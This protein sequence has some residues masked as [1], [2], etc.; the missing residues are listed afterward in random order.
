MPS[1][2]FYERQLNDALGRVLWENADPAKE[3]AL[4][5]EAAQREVDKKLKK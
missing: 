2:G 1:V 5:V 3:V 4:A